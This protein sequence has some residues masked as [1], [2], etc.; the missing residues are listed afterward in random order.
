MEKKKKNLSALAIV[1]NK[2]MFVVMGY[3]F[4]YRNELL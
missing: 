2:G 4:I 1:G 3:T